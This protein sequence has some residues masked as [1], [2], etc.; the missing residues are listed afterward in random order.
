MPG[1]T[2]AGT[3]NLF[4]ACVCILD[5]VF[6][7]YLTLVSFQVFYCFQL[8]NRPDHP[9][10]RIYRSGLLAAIESFRRLREL[11]IA[12][13]CYKILIAFAPLT[14]DHLDSED[15]ASRIERILALRRVTVPFVG[16][17]EDSDVE[18]AYPFE[19]VRALISMPSSS[20]NSPST[21]SSSNTDRAD[22]YGAGVIDTG[23]EGEGIPMLSW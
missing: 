19:A 14:N 22:L 4:A 2:T 12:D 5:L 6:D 13:R 15:E 23:F 10:N 1:H 18:D 11:P 21:L 3:F 9:S 16:V 8:L 20:T 7:A 17:P